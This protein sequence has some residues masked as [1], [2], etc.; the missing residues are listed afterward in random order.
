MEISGPEHFKLTFDAKKLTANFSG[1]AN[2]KLPKLYVV[3]AKGKLIYVGV[4]RQTMRQ[5]L[6]AGWNASG[7]TGYYGYAWRHTHTEA[8]LYVWCHR[9][10]PMGQSLDLETVEGEVVFMIRNAGQWPSGQTEIHFHPSGEEHRELAARIV[11]S[12][13]VSTSHRR[14]LL[15]SSVLTPNPT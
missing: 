15:L 7:K 6:Y 11:E 9:D 1:L 14:S 12:V 8:D 2:T 13:R 3:V 4:T 10:A 5:R